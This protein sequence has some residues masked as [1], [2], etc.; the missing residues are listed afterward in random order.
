VSSPSSSSSSPPPYQPALS[1]ALQKRLVRYSELKPCINAFIDARSPGSDKKENFTII[2]PGVAENRMASISVLRASRRAA[3]IHYTA[4]TPLKSSSSIR[5]PGVSFGASMVMQVKCCL[6]RAIQFQSRSIFF[7]ASKT[8]AVMLV[9]CLR[10]WGAMI[11]DAC[12]G[13]RM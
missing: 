1:S 13:R 4:T 8:L 9:S 3:P 12:I 10:C 11:R 6:I 5:A 2:G 7:A